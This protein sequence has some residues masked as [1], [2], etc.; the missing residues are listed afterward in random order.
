MNANQLGTPHLPPQR[1]ALPRSPLTD[2]FSFSVTIQ[3][4]DEHV[5]VARE[6]LEHRR[7]GLEFLR[8]SNHGGK[9][10]KQK[11]R[12]KKVSG[13]LCDPR[14]TLAL[15][16]CVLSLTAGIC[17]MTFA[18]KNS[19]F[20]SQLCQPFAYRA[21]KSFSNKCPATLVTLIAQSPRPGTE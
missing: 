7:E 17:L 12:R 1:A 15:A 5:A 19:S 2:R 3:P 4:H 9:R 13:G 11:N 20:G 18:L 8:G 14:I 21:S 6:S 10:F 16:L